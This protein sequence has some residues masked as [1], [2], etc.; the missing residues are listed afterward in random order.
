M[1]TQN[2]FSRSP[3]SF[4][5]CATFA[6]DAILRQSR[7]PTANRA[8]I[9]LVRPRSRSRVRRHACDRPFRRAKAP[10]LIAMKKNARH[11]A[12][13]RVRVR[14]FAARDAI[15]APRGAKSR[16]RRRARARDR[17][18][19]SIALFTHSNRFKR[20]ATA[21]ARATT[22]GVVDVLNCS[23]AHNETDFRRRKNPT[24]TT[25]SRDVERT[26]VARVRAIRG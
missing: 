2:N 19:R 13:D 5:P 6:R 7:S 8:P 4:A 10:N 25:T 1:G 22:E 9:A 14:P 12:R 26:D 18:A 11:H 16:A 3:P 17:V 20:R 21:R 23:F 15:A 24:S